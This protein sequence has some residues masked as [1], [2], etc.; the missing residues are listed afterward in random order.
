M[1]RRSPRFCAA[2]TSADADLYVRHRVART[3]RR[4]AHRLLASV[5]QLD[6][7]FLTKVGEADLASL[8]CGARI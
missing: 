7:G 3:R 1:V 6:T 8:S 5:Y 2:W 4:A